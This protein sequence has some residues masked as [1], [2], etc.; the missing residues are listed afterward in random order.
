VRIKEKY[1]EREIYQQQNKMVNVFHES[2]KIPKIVLN[3]KKRG[4]KVG[5]S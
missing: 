4:L 3:I 5:N 2:T 1:L